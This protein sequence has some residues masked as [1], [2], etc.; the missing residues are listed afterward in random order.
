M[1]PFSDI[2]K[3]EAFDR[4]ATCFLQQNFGSVG[5]SDLELLMFSILW[6]HCKKHNIK[7]DDY[8]LSNILG[9]TQ[10]RFR[11]L[12]VKNQLRYPDENYDW[13]IELARLAQHLQFRENDSYIVISIDN[14]LLMI[15]IQHFIEEKGGLVDRS[16]NPKLLK[17]PTRDFAV[18][19]MEVG[20]AKNETAVWKKLRTVKQ[21]EK[22]AIE[23]ITKDNWKK[24]I[25]NGT[26]ELAKII[27]STAVETII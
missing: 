2:E 16:F 5:K 22:D 3:I 19:M 11:N 24:R 4:I 27:I 21:Q 6:N 8:S 15:E 7:C 17:M 14:P 9:I 18:L 23:A 20:L 10:Q 13:K 1:V 26:V 12:K 25:Y